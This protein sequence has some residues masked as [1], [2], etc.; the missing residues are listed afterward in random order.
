MAGQQPAAYDVVIVGGGIA[1]ASIAYELAQHGRVCLLEGEDMPGIHSTG[2]SAALLS[3]SYG[4]PIISALTRAGKGFFERPPVNFA[5]SPLLEPRGQLFIARADQRERIARIAEVMRAAGSRPV[6]L[7]PAETQKL[8][9]LLRTGYVAEAVL[10]PDVMDIDV[11]VLHQGFL[12]GARA[13]GATLTMGSKVSA[14]V[15]EDGVWTVSL[16]AGN[17]RAPVLVNAAGAWADTVA[18]A[19]GARPLDLAVLRRTALLIDPPAGTEVESWPAVIDPNEEF[20]FKPDAGKLLLSPAD[21]TPDDPGDAQPEELDI[22]IA[23]DRV[24]QALDIEVRRVSHSWA[25]LRIF[26]PDRAPVLGFDPHVPGFFWCAG[27]GGT[28]IQTSPAMG[29]MAAALVQGKPV[30]EEMLA[31][32]LTAEMLSPGRFA[33]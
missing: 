1:G 10:D 33:R 20:Y 3:L 29:R 5:D 24:Q 11:D 22:A 7:D 30:P 25:G 13:R 32:G 27:Q 19:C 4:G 17:V 2:R 14:I 26:A 15:R 28:G 31:E 8:V 23:V 16:P 9:P 6:S 21:E 18:A 12:R